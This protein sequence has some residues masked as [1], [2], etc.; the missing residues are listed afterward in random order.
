MR[1]FRKE[2]KM[3]QRARIAAFENAKD[4]IGYCGIWCGS[5]VVGSGALRRLSNKYKVLLDGYGVLEWG[6]K[7]FD[8]LEFLKGL[9]SIGNLA[10]CPGC[11]KGG[12]RDD[13]ELRNCAVS[14][15]IDGCI[16]C[17]TQSTCEHQEILDHMRTGALAAGLFV[18]TG[19]QDKQE[20]IETWTALLEER[21]P[22]CLLFEEG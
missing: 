16:Q 10:L 15:G 9:E 18:K 11:L 22:C 4:Q 13:C 6:P 12:G 7:E 5:C 1:E 21:F 20:L 14:K 8:S 3:E 19:N 17:D 2:W